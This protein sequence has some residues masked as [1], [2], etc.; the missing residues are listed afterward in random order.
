MRINKALFTYHAIQL[1]QSPATGVFLTCGWAAGVLLTFVVGQLFAANRAELTSLFTYL[2]WVMAVLI[3]TLA[4]PAA[5]EA[6]RGIT[7]R[8]ATLP[9]TPLQRMFSRFI[10]LWALLGI[11]VLGFWPLVATLYYLGSPDTGPMLTGLFGTW[12][13]AA[14]LLALSLIIC[15]RAK[16]GV[17]GLLGAMAACAGLLALGTTTVGG[18]FAAVPGFGWLPSTAQATLLGAYQPFTVGLLNVSAIFFLTGA[19]LFIIGLGSSSRRTRPQLP[20]TISGAVLLLIA[21][22]PSLSWWQIDTTADAL[23]TP[24]PQSLEILRNL[25]SPVT[26]TLHVSQNNPDVPPSV[27]AAVSNMKT[28]LLHL[29]TMA[30]GKVQVKLSNADSSIAA[31]VIALQAGATEQPLPTGTTYF[32]ALTAQVAENIATMPVITAERQPVQEYDLLTLTLKAQNQTPPHIT[33]IAEDTA[34]TAWQNALGNSFTFSTVSAQ[35]NL[36]E[37]PTNTAMVILPDNAVLPADTYQAVQTYLGG[38]GNLVVFANPL[39]PAAEDDTRPT[40]LLQNLGIIVPSNTIVADPSLATLAQ[41]GNSGNTAYPYWLTLTQANVN[42]QLPFT[43]GASRVFMPQTAGVTTSPTQLPPHLTFSPIL[44]TSAQGRVVG[45]E[46][47]RTTPPSLATASLPAAA[48]PQVIAA[49]V[50]GAL[51]PS[52]T[53]TANAVVFGSTEWLTDASIAQ[54]PANLTLFTNL[55][56]Y[57]S[58][59]GALTSLRAKG[60]TP[61]TLTK[62]E[63]MANT[64]AR[65]TAQTEQ[66]IATRLNE[67]TLT[68]NNNPDNLASAQEEEFTLRQQLREVRQQTRHRLQSLENGLLLLNLALMPTLT[69][70]LFFLQRRRQRKQA[71]SSQ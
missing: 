36:S 44:T 9:F 45:L 21:L 39:Q 26:Y 7:E 59:Q 61:R 57:L 28:L 18:W 70:V 6:R 20:V 23:H 29:R 19:T 37:I 49:M 10:V 60:A 62:I 17:G 22:I 69:G 42:L 1:R 33:V 2:P 25:P 32:A 30:P 11:W 4:M 47:Y 38:G 12:L 48:G 54:A 63:S 56:H 27:L 53:S 43:L 24:S 46:A 3:P 65:Q 5:T 16:S 8:L 52:A 40:K 14:P 15:L 51:D 68:L 64:I 35:Q 41:Q 34:P 13:L 66:K 71:M 55:L 31:A 58:G 50:S 67:V